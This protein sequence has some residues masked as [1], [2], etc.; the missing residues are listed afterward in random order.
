MSMKLIETRTKVDELLGEL[1]AAKRQV[2][3]EKEVLHDLELQAKCIVKA[4][5]ILQHV[6][7]T[8][9][10]QAH[11]RIAGVANECLR[12]VF[13]DKPYQFK[14]LFERKRGRTEAKLVFMRKKLVLEDPLNQLSGGIIDVVAFAL[15]LSSLMLT[16]PTLRKII[17]MD[18]PF[19]NV[20]PDYQENVKQM[21]HALEE[22]LGVQ[23][24]L[25]SHTDEFKTGKIINLK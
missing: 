11:E 19:E 20:S 4:Q 3:Q 25:F 9:Q 23:L 1:A 5:N 24:I 6:A 21:V 8:I 14:I 22:K 15:Q 16:K 18:Q 10:Q 17:I 13:P 2:R 12:R 7:Q